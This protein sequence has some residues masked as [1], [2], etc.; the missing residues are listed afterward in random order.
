MPSRAN[1]RMRSWTGWALL[2]LFMLVAIAFVSFC[3]GSVPISLNTIVD[4]VFSQTRTAEFDI[5]IRDRLPRIILAFGVGSSL[6]LSGAF[7]QG[8]FRNPLVEPYTL[9]ISGGAA[10]GVTVAV[11]LRTGSCFGSVSLPAFG[12]LGALATVV[13]IYFLS[14]RRGSLKAPNMLLVGVMISFIASSAVMLLMALAKTEDLHGIVFWTMGSL[15]GGNQLL[16]ALSPIAS[17]VGLLV[18]F[19]CSVPLNALALGDEE[20]RHLGVPVERTRRVLFLVASLLTGLAVSAAG[21]IGFV[22]LIIPH[23]MRMIVGHDHRILL[24][25]SFLGGAIFLLASDT[26]ARMIISPLELPVGVITG[27]LGGGVFVFM[28]S[29]KQLVL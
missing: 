11:V 29:R 6:S 18:S 17:L 16:L 1:K 15:E 28:L 7:L 14:N 21:I 26:V 27:I 19:F 3:L 8:I 22:G 23:F 9:G 4:V 13:I 25:S 24:V 5:L 12:F 2:F 10:L 20:A